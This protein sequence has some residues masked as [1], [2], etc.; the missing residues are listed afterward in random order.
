MDEKYLVVGQGLA[1]T[2]LDIVLNQAGY[3]TFVLNQTETQS[4]SRVA[5]GIFNPVTG[6][7]MNKTWLADVIFPKAQAFYAGVDQMLGSSFL[8]PKSVFKIFNSVE[9]Q[10]D[11][12]ARV[13]DE[14][15]TDYVSQSTPLELYGSTINA[16]FGGATFLGGGSVDV[17]G[18]IEAYQEK[19]KRE[20][21]YS[22][23]DIDYSEFQFDDDGVSWQGE[24]YAG[25]ICCEGWHASKNPFF[26]WLPFALT[27]GEMVEVEIP[28]LSQEYIVN[29][30][31]FL[32][33]LGGERFLVGASFS[34]KT[35]LVETE[36]MKEELLHKLEE[37][38]TLPYKFIRCRVGIR[39]TV[40]DRRPLIGQH[41]KVK[42]LFIFNGLGTKGVTL[43]PH[44]AQQFVTELGGG[45]KINSEA[46]INR[47]FSLYS[48]PFS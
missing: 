45:E 34:R 2:V 31:A 24:K 7:R 15:Y 47:Y 8:H 3:K 20:N 27:T 22:E 23:V 42:H 25:L 46:N 4:S 32:L 29:K 12:A 17:A 40:K 26:S 13:A 33:P 35:Y 16:P 41:P 30:N 36:S 21:R 6:H 10:N 43:A 39:P 9:Q 1:G 38:V 14:R 11:V 18:L 44:F 37:M 28:N 5:A 48:E 19:L